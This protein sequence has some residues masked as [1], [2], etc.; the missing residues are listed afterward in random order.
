MSRS[1]L[2][3]AMYPRAGRALNGDDVIFRIGD[4][5]L[6]CADSSALIGLDDPSPSDACRYPDASFFHS[7]S[8]GEMSSRS[9]T[10]LMLPPPR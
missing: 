8:D 6:L 7:T 10:A 2:T 5:L 1:L 9:I 4:F 3:C